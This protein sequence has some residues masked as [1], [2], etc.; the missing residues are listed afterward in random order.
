MLI[1]HSCPAWGL[2]VQERNGHTGESPPKGHEGDLGIGAS[3]L[4]GKAERAGIVQPGA[5]K[6]PGD[7]MNPP[8]KYLK[9]ESA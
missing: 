8:Y 5:E 1:T 9:G 4:W 7:L 6:A 3:V 2:S